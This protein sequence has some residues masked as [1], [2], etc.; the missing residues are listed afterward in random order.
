MVHFIRTVDIEPLY[1][2]T[3]T[4]PE[5][6]KWHGTEQ[7]LISGLYVLRQRIPNVT[8]ELVLFTRRTY[9]Q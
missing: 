1:N 3:D 9:L 4:S 6:E 2:T 7:R 5:N 8:G